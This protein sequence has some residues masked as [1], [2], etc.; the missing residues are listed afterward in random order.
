MEMTTAE[1]EVMNKT[2]TYLVLIQTLNVNRVE[3]V[4]WTA[5]DAMEMLIVKMAVM[6]IQLYAV[7]FSLYFLNSFG[8]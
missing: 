4:F 7:S 2:A 1:T 5:G 3:D 6:K 8:S